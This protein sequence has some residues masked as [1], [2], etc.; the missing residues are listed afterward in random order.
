MFIAHTHTHNCHV[1]F[2]KEGVSDG[3]IVM[4]TC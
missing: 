1:V 3:S 2:V 4:L